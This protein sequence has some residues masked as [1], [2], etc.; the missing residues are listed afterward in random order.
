M[1]IVCPSK[2]NK[3]LSDIYGYTDM[4]LLTL[5]IAV[6]KRSYIFE[7]QKNPEDTL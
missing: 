2:N 1:G 5:S 4:F 7:Y 6:R 3:F